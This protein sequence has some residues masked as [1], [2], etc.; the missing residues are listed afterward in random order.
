M[1]TH[2]QVIDEINRLE[3]I[4]AHARYIGDEEKEKKI[5][6]IVE[7][8]SWAIGRESVPLSETP[9]YTEDIPQ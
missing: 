2:K 8:L 9:E 7:E 3:I 1:R 5:I 6:A 4:L